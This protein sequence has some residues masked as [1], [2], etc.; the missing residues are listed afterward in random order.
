MCGHKTPTSQNRHFGACKMAA[1]AWADPDS[2]KKP[3]RASGSVRAG[4]R[5]GAGVS[6]GTS[7]AGPECSEA[8]A[9]RSWLFL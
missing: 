2:Q 5:F 4:W 8:V 6:A 7:P 9:D 3:A 1:S